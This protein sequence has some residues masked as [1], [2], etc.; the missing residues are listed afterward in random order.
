MK[1]LLLI[2]A[3]TIFASTA[4]ADSTKLVTQVKNDEAEVLLADT[5]GR[6]LYVF[7]QD[8][9]SSTSKCTA[10]CAEVWPPYIVSAEEAAA[11]PAGL[12][13]V[14]RA[15]KKLQLTYEGRPLYTF[16]SD[17]AVGDDKGNDLGSVWHYIEIK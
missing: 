4:M 16:A 17:R 7:D 12:G 11:L 14:V 9:G 13:T 15:N 1:S 5:F 3:L 2:S 8:L 10:D 6:T